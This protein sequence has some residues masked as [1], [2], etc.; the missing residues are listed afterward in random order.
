VAGEIWKVFDL[1]STASDVSK[2]V[3]EVPEGSSVSNGMIHGTSDEDTVVELRH[4]N[5]GERLMMTVV[6]N[7]TLEDEKLTEKQRNV[8]TW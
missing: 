2:G 8:F 1:T 5:G 6:T 3:E 4:L 7:E